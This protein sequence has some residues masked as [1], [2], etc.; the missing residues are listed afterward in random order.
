MGVHHLVARVLG[1]QFPRQANGAESVTSSECCEGRSQER[2]YVKYSQQGGLEARHKRESLFS[3]ISRLKGILRAVVTVLAEQLGRAPSWPGTEPGCAR[4][5]AREG[6]PG[7][8]SL[9]RILERGG[10][11]RPRKGR[12]LSPTS[13]SRAA[14]RRPSR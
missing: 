1:P 9:G 10:A 2:I 11:S 4:R 7:D 8:Q 6:M 5:W 14:G 3:L 13:R 12:P